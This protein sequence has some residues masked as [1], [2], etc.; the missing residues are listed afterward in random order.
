MSMLADDMVY[1]VLNRGNCRMDIFEKPEDFASFIKLL[2]QA[3]RKYPSVRILG[4]C[5]MR[6]HWHLVLWPK[7]AEDLPR[8]MGWLSGTHVRRWREHRGNVGQGHLYQ[9]RYKSFAVQE[10]EHL[11]VVLRY[12]EANPLR[13]GMVAAAEHWLWSS[14]VCHGGMDGYRVSLC[15]WPIDRPRDWAKKVNAAIDEKMLKRLRTSIARGSPLGDV[16]W[17]DRVV[18]RLGLESTIR[19]PWRPAKK[20]R[21]T[22]RADSKHPPE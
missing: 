8:F 15:P 4:Y 16:Q 17:M 2:E 18:R 19:D 20:G 6:N 12:V 9:G 1:H 14:L 11:L 3:R 21:V 7:H 5:L 10:D 22:G 13:A